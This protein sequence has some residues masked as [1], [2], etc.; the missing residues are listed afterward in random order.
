LVQGVEL[1][2]HDRQYKPQNPVLHAI[3][4]RA[5]FA[6]ALICRP[7][8]AIIATDL[9]A[10]ASKSLTVNRLQFHRYCLRSRDFA[11]CPGGAGRL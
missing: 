8:L 7:K 4:R 2:A 10:N 6:R 11:P 3:D 1:S 9:A 5:I